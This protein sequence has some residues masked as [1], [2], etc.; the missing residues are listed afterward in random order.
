[1]KS[2]NAFLKKE[3]LESFRSGKITILV[4]I[5]VLFGILNPAIAKLTP[6]MME[7]MADSLAKTGMYVTEVNVDALTSWTQFFKNIPLGLIAFILV[8]SSTFTKEYQSGT[9]VL[10]LTKGLPRSK[11]VLAKSAVLLIM[12]TFC[13]WICFAITYM[14]N[15]FFW[16]NS[17]VFNLFFA[18]AC[19]W[20]FGVWIICLLIIFSVIFKK[21]AGVLL[22]ICGTFMVAYIMGIVPLIREFTPIMLINSSSFLTVNTGMFSLTNAA[23]TAIALSIVCIAVSIPIMNKKQL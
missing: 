21:N 13:Y 15:C 2:L 17:V 10:V 22:G 11:I 19:W 20:L 16:D 3:F 8:Y 18:T 9:L 4:I 12:W 5:F 14:Y 23:I 7:L 6:W 1:M